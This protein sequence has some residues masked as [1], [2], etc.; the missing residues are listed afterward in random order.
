MDWNDSDESEYPPTQPQHLWNKTSNAYNLFFFFHSTYELS[1]FSSRRWSG[2]SVLL[3]LRPP[4]ETSATFRLFWGDL[5][6]CS[7]VV[8]ATCLFTYTFPQLFLPGHGLPNYWG[9]RRG[10]I[11][12]FNTGAPGKSPDADGPLLLGSTPRGQNHARKMLRAGADVQRV[13]CHCRKRSV[14]FKVGKIECVLFICELITYTLVCIFQCWGTGLQNRISQPTHSSTPRTCSSRLNSSVTGW[15]PRLSF[16]FKF[17]L[18][19]L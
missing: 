3:T 5:N 1:G 11:P 16:L 2:R 15:R 19:F 18:A 6:C 9:I 4:G 8:C 13:D 17:F 12:R 7:L 14:Y 10:R